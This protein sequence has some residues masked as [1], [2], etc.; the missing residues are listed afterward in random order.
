[1]IQT[2]DEYN[3]T[4]SPDELH[5]IS[6]YLNFGAPGK[7]LTDIICDAIDLIKDRAGEGTDPPIQKEIVA[8]FWAIKRK[9]KR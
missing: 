4:F 5:T 7:T 2:N 8:R 1:M 6:D 3:K 9:A